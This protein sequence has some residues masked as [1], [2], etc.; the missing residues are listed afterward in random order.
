MR[1]ST[2]NDPKMDSFFRCVTHLKSSWKANLS[3][4]R[5]QASKMMPQGFQNEPQG[6]K[7]EPSDTKNHNKVYEKY[8][9]NSF[10]TNGV[11]VRDLDVIP[12]AK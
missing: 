1:K 10:F 5:P 6:I 8:E 3:H 2:K 9:N 7:N 12:P 11:A 4:I